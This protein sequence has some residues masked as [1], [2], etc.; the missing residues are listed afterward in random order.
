MCAAWMAAMTAGVSAKIRN[1]TSD[2]LDPMLMRLSDWRTCSFLTLAAL[3]FLAAT[4]HTATAQFRT[5][6]E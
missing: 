1:S 5:G 4:P 2:I 6:P 3:T